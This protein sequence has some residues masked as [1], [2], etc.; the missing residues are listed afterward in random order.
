[1]VSVRGVGGVFLRH[2]ESFIAL[3]EQEY[4][5]EPVLQ[6]LIAEHPEILAGDDQGEQ[7]TAWVL[8]KQ[9]ASIADEEEPGRRMS[10]DHLYL[11]AEAVPTLV[12]VKRSSDTRIRREVVG[13][14]L[15]YAANAPA[16]WNVDALRAW[17]ETR[18]EERDVDP[19]EALRAA[20]PTVENESAY[21]EAVGTNLA[22]GKLRLVF[23]A[24]SIPPRLRRIVEFL[25]GQM[26][27][28]EVLAIEVKQYVDEARTQQTIVPRVVG[29]TEAARQVKRRPEGR[30][31]DQDSILD[32]LERQR[33]PQEAAV[34]R[35]IFE[36]VNTHDDLRAYYGSG[37]KDGSF[38]AGLY[39][40]NAYL[41]PF[42]FYTYGR[43]EVQFQFIK[44]RP[45]FDN[46]EL[47]EQLRQRLDAIPDVDM[48][49]DVLDRR[50]SIPLSVLTS[51]QALTQV[52][53]AFDW[54]F[55]QSR[56][57]AADSGSEE[58][59]R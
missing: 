10:L 36:W 14:M 1:M 37:K 30:A 34:A 41:F 58:P 12:E 8:V 4:E 49:E 5:T 46:P 44:R 24:D 13:Q 54:A 18:C 6:S 25:N 43:L 48:P 42:V 35:R 27:E 53:A 16:Y 17:Y 45:P 40:G 59:K 20:F 31:W 22:A 50:P 57:F 39:R 33:G 2:G 38:Q 21:W 15:D 19:G 55:A 9:E 7:P 3:R 32:E 11:D 51:E 56:A 23:V 28:T 26:A 47:R 52:L 29:Q